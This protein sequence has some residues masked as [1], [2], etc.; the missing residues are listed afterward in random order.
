VSVLVAGAAGDAPN[1]LAIGAKPPNVSSMRDLQGRR[2]ALFGF[3]DHKAIVFAFLGNDCPVANLYVP[4]LV[5]LERQY[6]AKGVRFVAVNPNDAETIDQVAAHAHDRDVPFLVVKDFGHRL[7]DALGIERTPEVAV[8]DAG[9]VLRYRGAIDDQYGVG[10][11]REQPARHYLA[12]ALDQVLDGKDVKEAE[13]ACDGC[14]IERYRPSPARADVTF[15]RDVAPILQKRCQSC[16]RPGQ[17][18]PFALLGYDDVVAHAAT[19]KEAVVERR[20]PPWH[21]DR[22]FGRFR[23]D[24]SLTSDEIAT[25]A[26]W[27]DA[28]T[29]RGDDR[30]LPKPVDWPEG[31]TIGKPD[32]VLAMQEEFEVPAEGV[33]PY[34]RFTVPTG[35]TEDR[36][37]VAAET[38]PSA[39]AVV[40]HILV[41]I[42]TPGKRIY[43]IEGNTTSLTGTAP[44]DMPLVC[45][46]GV[47]MRIPQGANLLFEVHYTPNGKAVKDRSSVAM[48]FAKE[49]PERELQVNIFANV[50]IRV[51]PGDP[52]YRAEN[53]HVFREDARILSFM[54]HMH[55]RGKSWQ[56]EATYPDGR[57]E[58]LLS[59]PR[60]DFNWQSI[61]RFAEP[62]RVPKGTKIRAVAHWDN[63]S[64]NPQ[65]PDPTKE[66]RYGPQTWD[67]MMNG[68]IAY[69]LERP[70]EP[71][72]GN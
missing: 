35:F 60:W 3:R 14:L 31:W 34:K 18:G 29:P 57:Q 45:P 5:T 61:Y 56:Y 39:A 49:P 20:M 48:I 7:A 27:V 58:T 15:A 23:N 12:A 69:V 46:P 52:H 33:V 41:Y 22:R 28:G 59:I 53:V 66:I 11:R 1:K 13:T 6:R 9:F 65:N 67:E 51:P 55:T 63:S 62:V 64:A 71:V 38:K 16:H 72:R 8:L 50:L 36:W 37:V 47:A 17:V 42:L 19:L 40:H 32:L 68:W 25:L 26:A 43:D 24:R 2:R 21:A 54:P 70:K 10:Y 30:E 4:R 44:G